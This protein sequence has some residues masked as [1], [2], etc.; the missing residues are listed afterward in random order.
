MDIQALNTPQAVALSTYMGLNDY[1][2]IIILFVLHFNHYVLWEYNI[3]VYFF[4]YLIFF[5]FTIL[6]Q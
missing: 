1:I 5:T 2:I 3:L 6:H 4:N